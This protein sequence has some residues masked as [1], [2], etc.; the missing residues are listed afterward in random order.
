MLMVC[1]WAP[2]A[3]GLL[4]ADGELAAAG[5]LTAAG[6]L[7]AAGGL[8]GALAP[9][10]AVGELTAGL[11]QP[12]TSKTAARHTRR[13]RVNSR[14]AS[15]S[16]PTPYT[17]HAARRAG[18]GAPHTACQA[19][20]KR[21]GLRADLD[22]LSRT[23]GRSEHVAR[24]GEMRHDLARDALHLA[25][26]LGMRQQAEVEVADHFFNARRLDLLELMNDL[27]DGAGDNA[28]LAQVLR[29]HALDALGD[30]HEV[31]DVGRGLG[32]VLR[33]G[34]DEVGQVIQQ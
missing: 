34:R 6:E 16:S 27:L 29:L 4:A 26:R 22:G 14:I 7:A 11:L 28:A 13:L 17:R 19:P 1:P 21:R 2:P 20:G 23:S 25:Q 12:A 8:V 15:L 31:A 9:G 10:V 30:I 33:H 3:A 24:R 32:R 18:A 5:E